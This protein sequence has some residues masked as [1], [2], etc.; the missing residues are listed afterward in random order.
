[1]YGRPSC[2]AVLYPLH[3]PSKESTIIA[4]LRLSVPPNTSRIIFPHRSE[5]M[6]HQH[7]KSQ[8]HPHAIKNPNRHPL[9][10]TDNHSH[11]L[12]PPFKPET[13]QQTSSWPNS[14]S[15]QTSLPTSAERPLPG[16]VDPQHRT[17]DKHSYQERKA[18]IQ[19]T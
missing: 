12:K 7:S 6:I 13:I 14:T 4:P 9:Q 1:M 5:E 19:T 15:D 2:T 3:I 11:L 10:R 8:I 17:R 16:L 18:I